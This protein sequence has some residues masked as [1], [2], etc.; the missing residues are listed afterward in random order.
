MEQESWSTRPPGYEY[1]FLDGIV[2]TYSFT[3]D[4][5]VR[6]E[7]RFKPGPELVDNPALESFVFEMVILLIDNPFTPKLPPVDALIPATIAAVVTHFF[8]LRERAMVYL[9]DDSDAKADARRKLF[10]RWF[11]RFDDHTFVKR[12]IP[13]AVEQNGTAYIA[14]FV[15]RLDNPYLEPILA[16]F[17]RVISGEK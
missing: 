7:V 10:D 11:E 3:S 13:L 8:A 5:A 6:Y 1:A 2:Q 12:Q 16:S 4:T 14:E 17:T 9:C 15:A